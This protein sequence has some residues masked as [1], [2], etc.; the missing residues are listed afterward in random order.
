MANIAA[1]K[2]LSTMSMA[3]DDI[4]RLIKER[5]PDAEIRIEDLAGDGDHY[6]ATVTSEEF[7]GK[8]R[9]QQHQ[10]VY[11]ALKGNMGGVL[12]ALAL[13]TAAP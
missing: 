9:V 5:F 13:K 7:R 1:E 4:A 10:M 12:H 8:T 6:A 2:E 11:D 3:A